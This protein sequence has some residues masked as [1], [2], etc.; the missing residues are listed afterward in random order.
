MFQA[1][2]LMDKQQTPSWHWARPDEGAE[3]KARE[4]TQRAVNAFVKMQPWKSICP[5]LH[6]VCQNNNDVSEV[7][8]FVQLWAK[9]HLDLKWV[10]VF[11]R[12]SR[13]GSDWWL[14]DLV[15][16]DQMRH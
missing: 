1:D 14:K 9:R 7:I 11:G 8:R 3:V 4:K 5:Y 10:E 2:D 12:C 15:N 13:C 6:N 16:F